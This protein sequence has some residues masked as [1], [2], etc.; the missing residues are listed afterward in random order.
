[1]TKHIA[2]P[3]TPQF[4][5]IVKQVCDNA[6]YHN[7]AEPTLTFTG[8]VKLHGTNHAVCFDAEGTMYT[9]SRS[10]L[11]SFA[12][13]NA[14]SAAWTLANEANLRYAY[15]RVL[16]AHTFLVNETV[17]IFG[18]F[19]GG[20]IQQGVGV[21]NIAKTFI[22]FAIRI[23]EDSDSQKFLTP[24]EVKHACGEFVQCIYN[25]P[26]HTINIDFARPDLVC[27][28]IAVLTELVEKDC[29]VAREL[30]GSNFDKELIG[31][32]IVWSTVYK[33]N[34]LRF[35][36]KGEKHSSTK[37]RRLVQVDVDKVNNIQEFVANVLTNS[38]L[39]QGLENVTARE[40]K[41][42]GDFIKWIV[43]DVLKEEMDTLVENG[44]TSK[45]IGGPLAKAARNWFLT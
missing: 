34:T 18:E 43:K 5:D 2:Y 14:G 41:Y 27:E 31:E 39:N 40:S 38:R 30:L 10:N 44:F 32:G 22:V 37:T 26:T 13:D 6:K 45:D 33:G 28:T 25:F 21:N 20:N 16:G 35:K 42:T 12:S 11:T 17:Q 19:C 3:K 9:Q 4:R 7:E 8:S 1:M 23:S 15:E 36:V 24:A 29:P